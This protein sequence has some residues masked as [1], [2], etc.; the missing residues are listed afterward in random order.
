MIFAVIVEGFVFAA[1]CAGKEVVSV[2]GV[3]LIQTD[4]VEVVV[5][6]VV[7]VELADIA[8]NYHEIAAEVSEDFVALVAEEE[9]VVAGDFG[10]QAVDVVFA[11]EEVV[12]AAKTV[13]KQTLV[14]RVI[15]DIKEVVPVIVGEVVVVGEEAEE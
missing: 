7:P 4:V 9:P 8:D 1:E 12:A 14:H 5:K 3:L 13:A 11:G 6:V 10:K 2:V 15:V